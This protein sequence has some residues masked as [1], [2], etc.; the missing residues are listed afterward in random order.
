M[1]VICC[2]L[3]L[4]A[5]AFAQSSRAARG[6]RAD[7]NGKLDSTQR[8]LFKFE[9]EVT[10]SGKKEFVLA[11]E[12]EQNLTFRRGKD[13]K[14]LEGKQAAKDKSLPVGAHLAVEAKR[15]LNGDLTAVIVRIDSQK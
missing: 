4:A 3:I 5:V 9:G 1:R 12:G 10:E 14:I 11:V 7:S 13:M 15:E 8:L 6:R 2:V